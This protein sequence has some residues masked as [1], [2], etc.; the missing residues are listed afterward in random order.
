MRL[1]LLIGSAA[2][3]RVEVATTSKIRKAGS[4]SGLS[5]FYLRKTYAASSE[6]SSSTF[7]AAPR[8]ALRAR[9]SSSSLMH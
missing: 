9:Y 1:I 5:E 2:K 4:K 3:K 8:L 7:S 6:L